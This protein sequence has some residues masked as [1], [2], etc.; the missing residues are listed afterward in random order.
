MRKRH[1]YSSSTTHNT[2]Y[3]LQQSPDGT[4]IPITT[5]RCTGGELRCIRRDYIREGAPSRK[6]VEIIELKQ[7]GREYQ[8]VLRFEQIIYEHCIL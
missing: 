6:E 7:E 4:S 3:H 1:L 8:L 5:H 2:L